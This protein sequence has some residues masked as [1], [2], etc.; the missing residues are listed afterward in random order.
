MTFEPGAY[1]DMGTKVITRNNCNDDIISCNDDI[2]HSVQ[3]AV[4]RPEPIPLAAVFHSGAVPFH[5]PASL[6]CFHSLGWSARATSRH[7]DSRAP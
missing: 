5:S 7:G 3:D 6:T 2:T 1:V 4:D